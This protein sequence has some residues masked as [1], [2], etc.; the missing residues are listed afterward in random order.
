MSNNKQINNG[1]SREAS[2]LITDN[3]NKAPVAEGD[4][5][6]QFVS[7]VEVPNG[8]D[9]RLFRSTSTMVAAESVQVGLSD[10]EQYVCTAKLG[11]DVLQNAQATFQEESL[12][13][14]GMEDVESYV[15]FVVDAARHAK[16]RFLDR[17]SA[18]AAMDR[19]QQSLNERR[20]LY[21]IRLNKVL[22][23]L[24][25]PIIVSGKPGIVRLQ[26]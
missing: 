20:L 18:E 13:S 19:V 10:E 11:M 25:T 5:S 23:D 3:I 21:A 17:K 16:M 8:L 4:D 22:V 24:I 12:W 1:G 9:L 2:R 6:H 7:L 26:H 14:L 15:V